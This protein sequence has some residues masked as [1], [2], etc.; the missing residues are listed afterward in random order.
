MK[1]KFIILKPYGNVDWERQEFSYLAEIRNPH[2]VTEEEFVKEIKEVDLLIADVDINVTKK[3]LNS[4]NRLK[5]VVCA[6]TGTDFVDIP[7]A[8]RKGIVVT[9]LPDYC[10]E[11]VAEHTLALLFCLSRHVVLGAKASFEGNWEKR[12]MLQGIEVEGKILGIIGLGRIGRKVAE[13]AE[14]LGLKIAFYD[15]YVSGESVRDKRYEKKEAVA[16]LVRSSDIVTIHASLISETNRMFGEK[17][18]REMKPTAYFLN[19]AR[20]GIVDE[21]ALYR[22]L[23]ERWIAGAAVDVLSKEPPEKDH[24]MLQLDN[25]II[26]PHIAWNTREAKEKA[27]N[28]IKEIILSIIHHQFPVNVVNPEVRERWR[29]A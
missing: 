8:T 15:P 3:I 12:R 5:G 16:D 11:A 21:E 19:V 13:K 10:V 9:N 29:D 1:D 22:A 6:A 4:A 26:T 20:G 28:Q 2:C 27:R 7:E 25:I 14:A 24:P 23:K 18:F 17:E